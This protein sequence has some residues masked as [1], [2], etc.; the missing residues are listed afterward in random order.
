MSMTNKK[1]EMTCIV[2]LH[3]PEQIISMDSQSIH[4]LAQPLRILFLSLSIYVIEI[5]VVHEFGRTN[6][7]ITLSVMKTGDSPVMCISRLS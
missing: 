3:L 4:L 1:R 7:E 2:S 5:V 6:L